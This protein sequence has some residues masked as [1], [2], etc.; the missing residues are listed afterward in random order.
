M[1]IIKSMIYNRQN[2]SV[3]LDSLILVKLSYWEIACQRWEW[4]EKTSLFKIEH[5]IS[6]QGLDGI[7][8]ITRNFRQFGL[9]QTLKEL[10]I[11]NPSLDVLLKSRRTEI[12]QKLESLCGNI[13]SWNIQTCFY[14]LSLIIH[15]LAS[16]NIF[17]SF[18]MISI[19]GKLIN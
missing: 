8:N 11:E 13:F 4:N 14:I 19:L 9:N 17:L 3:T 7:I 2:Y 1:Q 16:G 15:T 10:K 12:N 5:C 6:I 18:K